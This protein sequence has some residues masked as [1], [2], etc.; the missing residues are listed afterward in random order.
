MSRHWLTRRLQSL[1]DR[2]ALIWNNESW[3]FRQ[4]CD[5]RDAW[6]RQL[7][8]HGVKP[9]DTLAICGDYSPKL[10]ALLLAALVNRNIIVPLASATAPR[11]NRLME[12]A[13]V[14]F[15]VR[16]EGD[17]SWHVTGFERAVSHPLLRGLKER[18]APGLVL[19]SSG[20]TGESKASVLDFDR[21]LAKFEVPRPAYRMLVF[22]LLDHI[23]GINTLLYGLCHGG[24]IVTTRERTPDAVCAA[25]EAR[26]IE[27]LPTTPTFLRI[28]L[29]ADAIR[30]YDLSSLKIVTYG[31]EPMPPS[32]LAVVREALPWVRFKQTYGL[33]ELGI[34]PTQSR[35]SGSVWLKLGNA[36]FEHKIVD[37]VLWIRSPSAMLGYLNAPS[38]FDAD[39][40]FNTQDLVE[41]EG[42]YIRILGRKSELINVGGE[43][44]HPTEI[45]NVLLQVDNVK[46]VTVRGQPN[47]VTGEVVAAKIT[48]LGPED[49]DTLKRRVRQFC[50]ARLERYKIPAVIDVVLE[51][52]Y[53]ARFKKS[54]DPTSIRRAAGTDAG[55]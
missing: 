49:P 4:L 38:P 2:P 45:E 8:Q 18:D 36:G 25:I 1:G 44:V 27:L 12:L 34:L 5:G 19:F 16:F 35:D 47:P 28:L 43:K 40:W 50:H 41:R 52:H 54:R 32:T 33:S 24:T 42:E 15:A 31:T 9:G 13:Q 20:S 46:D 55:S 53:G 30:R 6:L 29:I 7:A 51:D 17:D 21:L 26:R 39:G 10:C 22:L 37:G 14:Q 11:W 3:S 48:P 23:G